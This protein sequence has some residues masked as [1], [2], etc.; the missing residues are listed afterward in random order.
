MEFYDIVTWLALV[1]AVLALIVATAP[2]SAPEPEWTPGSLEQFCNEKRRWASLWDQDGQVS[3]A[4][5]VRWVYD[6]PGSVVVAAPAT[7]RILVERPLGELTFRCAPLADGPWCEPG[8]VRIDMPE[9]GRVRE[10]TLTRIQNIMD[11]EKS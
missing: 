8:H 2:R 9:H 6:G 4:V 3:H 1:V 10:I 5:P 7:F 11:E